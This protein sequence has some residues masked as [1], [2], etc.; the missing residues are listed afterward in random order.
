MDQLLAHLVGDYVL[1][2]HWMSTEKVKRW[3]PA[4]A[5][6]ASYALPFLALTRDP[7]RLA[8]IASTHVVID[9]YRLAKHVVWLKNQVGPAETRPGHTATGYGD[10]VPDFLKV[11][12]LILADNTIHLLI[13]RLALQGAAQ[14][15]R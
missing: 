2:S 12:L 15:D 9:R 8:V 7:R 11:W 3:G 10:E 13:N 5:H 1:Q 4:F 6:G 14:S